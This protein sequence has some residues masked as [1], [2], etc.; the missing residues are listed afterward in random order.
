M[1]VAHEA[2]VGVVCAA[3]VGTEIHRSHAVVDDRMRAS[4]VIRTVS[5]TMAHMSDSGAW[6]TASTRRS[7]SGTE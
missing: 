4:E 1:T 2:E 6:P 5:F 3:R 7:C